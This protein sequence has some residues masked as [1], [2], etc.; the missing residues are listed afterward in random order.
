MFARNEGQLGDSCGMEKKKVSDGDRR[1]MK[2]V[3]ESCGGEAEEG[4]G[5]TEEE[6]EDIPSDEEGG[7][8][9]LDRVEVSGKS[10]WDCE[11]ILRFAHA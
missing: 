8:E 6:D 10:Q 5:S 11:S 7:R 9:P 4:G 2:E 3:E 1:E